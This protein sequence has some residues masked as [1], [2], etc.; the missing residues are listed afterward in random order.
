MPLVRDVTGGC[1]TTTSSD[2]VSVTQIDAV[3]IVK[4]VLQ[5]NQVPH[6][7]S[8]QT[9]REFGFVLDLKEIQV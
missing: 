4:F 5:L 8:T 1:G 9:R 7:V 6:F 3:L 2:D